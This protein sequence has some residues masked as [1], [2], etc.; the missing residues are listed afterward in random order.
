MVLK[1]IRS[2]YDKNI[3]MVSRTDNSIFNDWLCFKAAS[4]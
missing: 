1:Y 3:Y 2:E 4:C